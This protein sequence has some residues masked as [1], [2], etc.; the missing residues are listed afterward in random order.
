LSCLT[1]HSL[2]YAEMFMTVAVLVRRF[3]LELHDTTDKDVAIARDRLFGYPENPSRG[4]R[5]SVIG[6]RD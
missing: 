6:L 3:S 2:A 4:V 5:V 1:F